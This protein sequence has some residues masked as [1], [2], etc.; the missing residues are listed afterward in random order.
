MRFI[1]NK[2]PDDKDFQPDESWTPLKESTSL[3]VIQLQAIPF[4]IINLALV[5]LLLMVIGIRFEL[6]SGMMLLAFVIS[7]P[8]HEFLHAL[9]FPE[10]LF[11]RNIFFGF[12]FKGLAPFAAYNG[13][14]KRGT[15]LKVLLAPF[16]LITLAGLLFLMIHGNHRLMEH[17]VVFNALGACADCLGAWLVLQQVPSTALVR[18][19]KI[20]TYWRL[21]EEKSKT[22][23]VQ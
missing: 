3:W 7:M 22:F 21:P 4:I 23:P 13:E 14:M 15:F 2:F 9:F 12:T 20:R 17:V 6:D 16:I 18:N 10:N 1:F 11:S 8:V 19:K 5:L